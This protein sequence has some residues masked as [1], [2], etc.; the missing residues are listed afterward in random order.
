MSSG[1]EILEAEIIKALTPVELYRYCEK[2]CLPD[3]DSVISF[4]ESL[5][6]ATNT[7]ISKNDYVTNLALARFSYDPEVV[8][9]LYFK[10]DKTIKIAATLNEN[11]EWVN[12]DVVYDLATSCDG[13]ILRSFFSNRNLFSLDD[14]YE[15]FLEEMYSRKGFW[16]NIDD[17]KW[18]KCVESSFGCPIIREFYHQKTR[19]PEEGPDM[20]KQPM[21]IALWNL[22]NQVPVND[23]WASILLNLLNYADR[24]NKDE[25]KEIDCETILNKWVSFANGIMESS[26]DN[27]CVLIACIYIIKQNDS[28]E[29]FESNDKYIRAAYYRVA[30]Y[31]SAQM[32]DFF[33]KDGEMFLD[34]AVQNYNNYYIEMN[35]HTLNQLTINSLKDYYTEMKYT[36]SYLQEK[37]PDSFLDLDGNE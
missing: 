25:C 21:L 33:E 1:K 26:L 29:L 24:P 32:D 9:K 22:P 5:G 11:S 35:R 17:D 14:K 36:L 10:Q 15:A 3:I 8:E 18:Q 34:N 6:I 28:E 2:Y 23:K 16:N 27:L 4:G 20:N 19:H 31:P 30:E 7:L 13:E 37:T 12:D